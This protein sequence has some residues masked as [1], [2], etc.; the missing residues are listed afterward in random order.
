MSNSLVLNLASCDELATMFS[1]NRVEGTPFPYCM[2]FTNQ[3]IAFYASAEC[4]IRSIHVIANDYKNSENVTQFHVLRLWELVRDTGIQAIYFNYSF[5]D[6]LV[7]HMF[8]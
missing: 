8:E 1:Y 5:N 6:D 4:R 3:A 7:E 2:L